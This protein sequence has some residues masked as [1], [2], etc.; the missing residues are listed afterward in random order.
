[1]T[2]ILNP[3]AAPP[4]RLRVWVGALRRT[5]VPQLE[6]RVDGVPRTPEALRPIQSARDDGMVDAAERRAFTG[7]YE[8]AGDWVRPGSWH[9]V[10]VRDRDGAA[11]TLECRTL[12]AALPGTMEEPFR[13]LMVSCYHADEDRR[14]MAGLMIS[15][16]QGTL[17]PH[18]TLLMGDQ[19]YLDLPTTRGFPDDLPWL[20]AKFEEDY[21]KN[22]TEPTGYAQVL[23]SAPNVAIPDDHEYWNNF[24]HPSP[25]IQNTLSAGGR[26]RWTTAARRM[27]EAFQLPY[28]EGLTRAVEIDVHPLS[29]FLMDSRTFRDPERE[30]SVHPAVLAQFQAWVARVTSSG[31]YGAVVG[32]QSFF[33]EPAQGLTATVGDRTLANYGDFGRIARELER[34][35]D[36]GRPVLCLTG[37][38]HWGRVLQTVDLHRDRGKFY[39]VIVSPSSLVTTVGSDQLASLG[40]RISGMFGSHNP[41]PRHTEAVDPP[42]YLASGPLGRR[43]ACRT[44]CLHRQKG[45]HVAMLSFRR[46]GFGVDLDI[47]YY[48][49]YPGGRPGTPEALDTVHLTSTT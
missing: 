47:T 28:P 33:E 30:H 27:F 29:F 22:W 26:A 32:G 13:V 4:D 19:V 35:A 2:L 48:S 43:F 36:A 31:M 25:F 21:V 38:V 17:R 7:V 23:R 39:E 24:P 16:L 1:M 15:Q 49:I 10:E 12:P 34:L 46:S 45:N 11:D 3:R 40:A 9:R 8:F 44:P 5:S 41:W 18:L 42:E 37:D 6:W 14:G 20:A